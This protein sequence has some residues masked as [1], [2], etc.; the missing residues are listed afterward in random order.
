MKEKI[1]W[2]IL[3]CSDTIREVDGEVLEKPKSKE[4]CIA[5][6]TKL[7]NRENF[8]HTAVVFAFKRRGD[9]KI[10]EK[11]FVEST[12]VKFGEIEPESLEIYASTP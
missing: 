9:G 11:S 12:L 5:Q 3:I 2:D 8:T 10:F 4:E 1:D 7:N 6:L